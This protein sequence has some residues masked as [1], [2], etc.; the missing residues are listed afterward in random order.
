VFLALDVAA[1]WRYMQP[2]CPS[3]GMVDAG[4]SKSP[5]RKYVPVRVRPWVPIKNKRLEK[6]ASCFS[7]TASDYFPLSCF[8]SMLSAS[9]LGLFAESALLRL[10]LIFLNYCGCCVASFR[11]LASPKLNVFCGVRSGRHITL[12]ASGALR[13]SRD[14]FL[15]GWVIG[16]LQRTI[17]VAHYVGF[18]GCLASLSTKEDGFFKKTRCDMGLFRGENRPYLLRRLQHFQRG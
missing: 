9:L 17:F 7:N 10:A 5:V 2:A 16:C 3:G 18:R 8:V 1:H 6:S 15:F 11:F 12:S 4:D 14:I 13:T